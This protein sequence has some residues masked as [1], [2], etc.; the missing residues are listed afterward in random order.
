[1]LTFTRCRANPCELRWGGGQN[2]WKED[3]YGLET[4]DSGRIITRILKS[5]KIGTA[6]VL[7]ILTVGQKLNTS[8]NEEK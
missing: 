2:H 5:P 4:Q 7:G 1:M 3:T 6:V 8:V